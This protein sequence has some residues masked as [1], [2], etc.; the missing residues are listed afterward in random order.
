[1]ADS[2]TPC[3][4]NGLKCLWRKSPAD[5]NVAKKAQ[6]TRSIRIS[7]PDLLLLSNNSLL[8]SLG[9][10]CQRAKL[11]LKLPRSPFC[12][13]CSRQHRWPSGNRLSGPGHLSVH[14]FLLPTF[15]NW[16]SHQARQSPDRLIEGRVVIHS[17]WF[18][19]AV[20]LWSWLFYKLEM[21]VGEGLPNVLWEGYIK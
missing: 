9:S 13:Y 21:C 19:E 17:H 2:C 3:W 15:S 16:F 11:Q 18:G 8:N 4:I 6:F 5:S 20:E 1:M 12:R 14:A 7:V 10:V